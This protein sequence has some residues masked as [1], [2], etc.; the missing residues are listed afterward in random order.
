[1]NAVCPVYVATESI[2]AALKE[3]SSP[4]AG[5][6]VGRYLESFTSAQTALGRLPSATEVA[7]TVYFLAS[8][9]ASAITGQCINVDCGTFP[10]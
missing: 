9:A 7:E 10:Q 1:M 5:T 3:P 8:P 4:A 2:L 6:A